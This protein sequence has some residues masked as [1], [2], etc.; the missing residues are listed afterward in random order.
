MAGLDLAERQAWGW[1]KAG[2][3]LVLDRFRFRGKL[4]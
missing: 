3:E 1:Q 2:L 4:V